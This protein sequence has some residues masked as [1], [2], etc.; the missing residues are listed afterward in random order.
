MKRFLIATA[1]AMVFGLASTGKVQA[2]LSYGY[3]LP[4][5]GGV[6]RHEGVFGNGINAASLSYYS[7]FTGTMTSS[8]GTI[9]SLYERG[10]FSSFYSPFSGMVEQ[11]I[12]AV[13]TPFGPMTYSTYYSPYTGLLA[14]VRP[15]N[16]LSTTNSSNFFNSFLPSNSFPSGSLPSRGG[17]WWRHR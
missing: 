6:E 10:S 5:L 9:N 11:S 2:Q 12:R 13:A 1:V 7:P 14:S 15:G 4:A 8:S 17:A 16:N 3:T